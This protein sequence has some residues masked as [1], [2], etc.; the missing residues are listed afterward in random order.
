MFAFCV[1]VDGGVGSSDLGIVIVSSFKICDLG[2]LNV[3]SKGNLLTNTDSPAPEK[4]RAPNVRK[5]PSDAIPRV[6]TQGLGGIRVALEAW[7][8]EQCMDR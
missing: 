7:R 2:I 3:L 1:E 6:R 8:A 4:W 5:P